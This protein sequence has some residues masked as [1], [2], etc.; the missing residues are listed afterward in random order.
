ERHAI[1]E[2]QMALKGQRLPTG[3]GVPNPRGPIPAA[4]SEPAA[5]RAERHA[6]NNIRVPLEFEDFLAAGGVP[7]PH[8]FSSPGEA[9]RL[10]SGLNASMR[11]SPSVCPCRKRISLPVIAS[12]SFTWGAL[13]AEARYLPSGLNATPETGPVCPGRVRISLPVVVSHSF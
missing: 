12:H 11:W 5:V 7:H 8:G 2:A 6:E 1:D 3:G 4:G 13:P 10:P 9:T